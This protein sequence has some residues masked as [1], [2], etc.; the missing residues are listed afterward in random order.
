MLASRGTR[1]ILLVVLVLILVV[2]FDFYRA[3]QCRD[4]GCSAYN[5]LTFSCELFDCIK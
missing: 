1:I 3:D 4:L 5:Y 2:A